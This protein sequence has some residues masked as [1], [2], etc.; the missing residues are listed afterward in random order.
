MFTK[1]FYPTPDDVIQKMLVGIKPYGRVFLEPHGGK[2]NIID[3]VKKLGGKVLTCELNEDL[4]T[5]AANKADSFLKHNFFDVTSD[6]VSH[7]DYIIMN[8]PF[9]NADQ[10]ISHAWEIAPEG[11]QIISLCNSESLERE[12]W[13]NKKALKALV[14]DHGNSEHLGSVF[15]KSERKTGVEVSLINLFKPQTGENEFTGYFDLAEEY[16]HH[17]NGVMKHDS[18]QEIVSR[19]VGAVRMFDD[20]MK[21]NQEINGVIDPISNGLGITFGAYRSSARYISSMS[22]DEFKKELQKSAWKTVFDKLNIKHRVVKSVLDRMNKFVEK[23]SNVPFTKNNIYKMIEII[24]GTSEETMIKTIVEV[25]DKITFHSEKNKYI[26]ETWKTNSEY[27]VNKKFILGGADI[28]KDYS[29]GVRASYRGDCYFL[30]DL[31]KALCYITGTNYNEMDDWWSWFS[32][33]R[34]GDTIVEFGE[35][36]DFNFFEIKIFKKMSIH[37]KFKDDQVW[38]LFNK[39]AAKEKGFQLAEKFTGDFRAK[40]KNVTKV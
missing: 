25:F 11:C 27:I 3:Y 10:H 20:V 5:I 36:Y 37:V 18:I 15:D 6:E 28:A 32:K 38:E 24:M 30:D 40:S 31:T 9:E 33:N 16:E 8:P 39:T 1:N 13:R 22:K 35:W 4:A 12:V 7:V 29:G 17:E 23:Q 26:A 21:I 19:Y 34:K 2:G 14:D